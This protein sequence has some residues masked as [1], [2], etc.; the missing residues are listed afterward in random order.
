MQF[1]DSTKTS[2]IL[3]VDDEPHIRGVVCFALEKAGFHVVEASD[4][5]EA[6]QRFEETSPSLVVLDIL[7]PQLDGIEVCRRLR[8]RSEVPIVFLSSKDEEIDRILGLE[9]GGDDYVVKPFSP[10]ELV[11]RVRAVLR[12]L[13]S[14][15]EETSLPL[16]NGKLRLDVDR[17]IAL[18][19]S[20]EVVLTATEFAVLRALIG[21]PGKVYSRDE[22]MDRVHDGV[23]VS[24]RTIDSHIRRLRRKFE[25]L[26][27][28]PIETVHGVGYK[29][30]EC[31]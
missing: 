24:Q 30:S 17:H 2:T 18:W 28:H 22:L 23:V 4:G 3:V 25:G 31:R 5:L 7:M 20:E 14:P 6:L 21:F 1:M 27:A 10:R 16:S 29:L 15:E 13:V 9:L 19:G 8:R 26:G 12:R 11:A